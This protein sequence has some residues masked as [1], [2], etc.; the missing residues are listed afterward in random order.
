[1]DNSPGGELEMTND[2]IIALMLVGPESGVGDPRRAFWFTIRSRS[3]ERYEIVFRVAMISATVGDLI[4]RLPAAAQLVGNLQP[5]FTGTLDEANFHELGA[6]NGF[7]YVLLPPSI[8]WVSP[9]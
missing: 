7:G 6:R 9:V 1:M 8:R 2:P 4:D 3:L 5:R